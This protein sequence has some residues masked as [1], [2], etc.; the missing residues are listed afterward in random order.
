VLVDL[1]FIP[2]AK[3]TDQESW[4]DLGAVGEAEYLAS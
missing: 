4:R 1:G 2:A 3:A